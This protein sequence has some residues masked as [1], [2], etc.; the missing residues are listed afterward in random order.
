MFYHHKNYIYQGVCI[1]EWMSALFSIQGC[2][3]A[4]TAK[5]L[6]N[7]IKSGDREASLLKELVYHIE[8]TF[9]FRQAA[10]SKLP[11]IKALVLEENQPLLSM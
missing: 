11:S 6:P 1:G 9:N 8:L 7:H 4:T 3:A 5:P 2:A 10:G